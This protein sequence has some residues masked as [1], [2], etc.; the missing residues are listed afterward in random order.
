MYNNAKI[1]C[2]SK[3]KP[4]NKTTQACLDSKIQMFAL[5]VPSSVVWLVFDSPRVYLTAMLHGFTKALNGLRQETQ[6]CHH[7]TLREEGLAKTL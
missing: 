1:Y 2:A 5:N 6:S 7:P 4:Q 3:Q